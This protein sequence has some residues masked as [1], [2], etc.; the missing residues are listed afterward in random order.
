M[1][2]DVLVSIIS[3]L[4]VIFLIPFIIKKSNE[5][6]FFSNTEGRNIHSGKISNF[7]GI[8]IFL[9]FVFLNLF[10]INDLPTSNLIFFFLAFFI[11]VVGIIDDIYD[12]SISYKIISQSL[13]S[14][15]I[16]YFLDLRIHNFHGIFNLYELPYNFSFIF[17]FFV[18]IFIINSFNLSD[19][20]DGLA[21]SIGV[22]SL[23]FFCIIFYFNDLYF[24]YLLSL[25]ALS[26]L[27]AFLYY[28]KFP[29]R[30]FMGDCGSL[31][32]GLLLSY[33]AIIS[34]NLPVDLNGTR[35]PVLV[36]C[37]LAYPSI[38][39]IRIFTIRLLKG[40]SPFQAD[41]NHIHHILINNKVSHTLS[42]I[43]AVFYSLILTVICYSIRDKT[44]LSFY[45]MVFL[46]IF[47]LIFLSP[48][49][50]KIFSKY[51]SRFK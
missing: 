34:C 43:I 37:V 21:S 49:I 14:I 5:F 40:K 48:M 4:I 25:S 42:S 33:F 8:A 10:L 28:N 1:L 47:F 50:L 18:I 6:N 32:I 7:G 46:A 22:F 23:L 41:N 27:L 26:S 17:T 29:A 11:F 3:F 44:N 35:N 24:D 20:L 13:I 51:F 39:T 9:S 12:I 30:V 45:I 15:S 16:I 36:L 31:F 2:V 38:D 19:G